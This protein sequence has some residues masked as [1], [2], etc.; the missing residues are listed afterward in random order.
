[1]KKEYYILIVILTTLLLIASC[2][3]NRRTIKDKDPIKEYDAAAF[4]YVYVEAL[5]QKL[6]GNGG[7]A[8]KYLEQCVRLN[9]F[10]DGAYYQMA[11]IVLSSGDLENGKKYAE[12]A[13]QIDD[14]NIWYIMMLSGIF[15]Q[16]GNIDSA[17]FIYEKAVV[18]YPQKQ[19]LQISLANLYSEYKEYDKALKIYEEFE[20]KFGI[21]ENTTYGYIKNLMLAGRLNEA[22]KKTEEGIKE[23]PAEIRYYG[24][25][26]EIYGDRGN[27]EKAQEV[28]QKLLEEN[29]GNAEIQLALCD[30]LIS[31]R[32]FDELFM[33]LNPVIL[34][35]E[36]ERENKVSLFAKLLEIKDFTNEQNDKL[37]LSF[38]VFEANYPT[39]EIIPLL[40]P[41]FLDNIGRAKE[42]IV[43][44]EELV[45]NRPDNYY[46]WERLLLLYLKIGNFKELMIKGEICAS[47]F[48]RSFLVKL[49]YA[50][51]A[52]ENKKYDV[53]LDELRKAQILA[54]DNNDYLVQ[55]LTMRADVYYR[56]KEYSKSFETFEEA[57][58]KDSEDLTIL[59]NYAYY[60]AEQNMNLKEAEVMARKVI[61]KEKDNP[62]FL[63]TYAW[64]LYKRGKIKD[65]ARIMEAVLAKESDVS[66]VYYEHYG[67]ILKS[68][69][70]CDKAVENW[71]IA[72]KMDSTKNELKGEISNC[73]KK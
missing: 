38:M 13:Y 23:F 27:K 2:V 6:M 65:A 49:L 17:I 46:V 8:L 70:K 44:L 68:M 42:A 31:E 60:L 19:N 45:T 40:R 73:R 43:R 35:T 29:P 24:L 41:Q 11:Q 16:E 30:F 71:S 59:N 25:L 53:A 28:Y 58:S 66:A 55:V 14:R 10:S 21:N 62:T 57:I 9:P 67:F 64:V 7:E 20:Q 4:D 54:G 22:Q 56:K 72:F 5:K 47:K 34:N 37:L 18:N 36:I 69:K 26:A 61:E 52:L 63:D 51:G 39:D 50:N 32:R 1:M 48:N 3:A 15:Y 33:T 12:K